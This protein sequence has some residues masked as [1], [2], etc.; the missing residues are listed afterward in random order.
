VNIDNILNR[1]KHKIAAINLLNLAPESWSLSAA[2]AAVKN[3]AKKRKY[4]A[5]PEEEELKSRDVYTDSILRT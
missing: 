2:A 3:L 4:L 1:S 5:A